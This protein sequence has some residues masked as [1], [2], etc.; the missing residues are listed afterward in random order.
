[1][2]TT[3]SPSSPQSAPPDA[4]RR[5]GLLGV[6]LALALSLAGCAGPGVPP[7][8]SPPARWSEVQVREL[9]ALGFVARGEDW[10][11]NLADRLT[12]EFDSDRLQRAQQS[13]LVGVALK[14]REV[15]VSSLRVEGHTDSTGDAAYNRQLSLRRATSVAQ[16]LLAAGWP[17]ERLAVVGHGPAKPIADNETE[18]GRAQNRRVALI[19]SVD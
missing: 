8:V 16:V 15:G 4:V 18:A 6:G 11:L 17:R 12:F 14:L 19:A 13:R 9:Q 1:M 5:H 7:P 3:S 10:E 2:S